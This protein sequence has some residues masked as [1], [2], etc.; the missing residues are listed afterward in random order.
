MVKQRQVSFHEIDTQAH[1]LKV[2]GSN[3]TPATKFT[4]TV[5]HVTRHLRVAFC[6]RVAGVEAGWKR[7]GQ[8]RR[9]G[10]AATDE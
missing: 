9:C 2:V 7:A 8:V 10:G 5:Q 3:P 6:V 4:S 1:N